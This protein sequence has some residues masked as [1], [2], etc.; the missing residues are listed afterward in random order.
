MS[1][2]LGRLS[3]L[4]KV[5]IFAF[6]VYGIG[7]FLLPQFALGTI[8]GFEEIPDMVHVRMVG[9]LFLGITYLEYMV[10][11]KLSERLDLVWGFVL[12]PALLF[13]VL[14]LQYNDLQDNIL[15]FW[16]SVV[17]TVFF[18]LGIGFLRLQVKS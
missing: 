16:V 14:M 11:R 8:F 10:D 2:E 3:L 4:M 12:V 7:W 1:D 17:V 15:F 6:L 5:Q 18:S 9:A 13:A